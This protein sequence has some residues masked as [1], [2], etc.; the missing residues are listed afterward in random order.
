MS[1]GKVGDNPVNHNSSTGQSNPAIS[2][3]DS[4]TRVSSSLVPPHWTHRRY[5]SYHSVQGSKPAAITLEDHTEEPTERSNSLWARA[6]TIDDHILVSGSLP[7]VG[8]FVVWVINIDTLDVSN[9]SYP[10]NP[11]CSCLK[12]ATD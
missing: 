7:N 2:E 12:L 11:P 10:L 1:V 6:V 3:S 8:K 5:E 4:D 9:I